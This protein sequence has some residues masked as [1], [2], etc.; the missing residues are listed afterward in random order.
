MS[1]IELPNTI[2]NLVHNIKLFTSKSIS[3]KIFVNSLKKENYWE[4]ELNRLIKKRK[5]S[6]A[7]KKLFS[8]RSQMSTTEF[9]VLGKKTI[10]VLKDL[11]PQDL[12]N[13]GISSDELERVFNRISLIER[14]KI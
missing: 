5:Y 6:L 11:K 14:E 7:L 2:K 12:K 9:V 13:S 3:N 10:T 8:W 1:Q 4:K